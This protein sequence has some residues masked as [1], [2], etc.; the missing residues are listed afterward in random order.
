MPKR[1]SVRGRGA[2]IF[3][4]DYGQPDTATVPAATPPPA[5]TPEPTPKPR[6]RARTAKPAA[7]P[8]ALPA[9][10]PTSPSDQDNQ[11]LSDDSSPASVLD[12]K[13]ASLLS[14]CPNELVQAIRRVVRTPGREVSF[15]RLSPAEK[16]QLADVAYAFKRQGRKTSE[17]EIHRIAVNFILADHTAHGDASILA[18]I[19]AALQD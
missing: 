12:S 15:V 4:G 6:T 10:E 9:Q 11:S 5:P 13:L 2:D 18:R 8:P 16:A 1:V 14:S 3:F 19:L 17:T 7:T